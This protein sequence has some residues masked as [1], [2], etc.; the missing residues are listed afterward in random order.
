[1]ERT[2]APVIAVF[3]NGPTLSYFALVFG[4]V[5]AGAVPFPISTNNSKEA[6]VHLLEATDS[7]FVVGGP[8]D[9][10]SPE[11]EK[12]LTRA[13]ETLEARQQKIG[14]IPY[15]SL[16]RLLSLDS[17]FQVSSR[18]QTETALQG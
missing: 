12:V 5:R 16:D 8:G 10:A 17:S 13:L 4:I 6:L 15:P 3:G 2:K 9:G 14:R 18:A 1:M 11:V 7:T